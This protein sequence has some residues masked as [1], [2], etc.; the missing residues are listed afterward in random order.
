MVSICCDVTCTIRM[1][2]QK[3]LRALD[4]NGG[5]IM[6]YDVIKCMNHGEYEK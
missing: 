2:C 3:F 4:V 5:K 6:V 1:E